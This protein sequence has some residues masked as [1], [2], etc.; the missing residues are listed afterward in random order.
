VSLFARTLGVLLRPQAAAEVSVL[1]IDE[2]MMMLQARFSIVVIIFVLSASPAF[3]KNTPKISPEELAQ[4]TERGR[5]LYAYDQAAWHATDAV[6]TTQPTKGEDGRYIARKTEAGW[7]AAFG[8]LSEA[9]D[10]FLIAHLASQGKTPQEFSV[11][12]FTTPKADTGF[13]FAAAKAVDLELKDFQGENVQ[14]NV[15]VLP[16]SEGQVY[17]YVL[18]A[19]TKNSVYPLGGDERYTVSSDGN[20]LIAKHRMHHSILNF[21][22]NDP[23]TAKI[24]A[25][26]HVHVLS[27]VPED[28]DVFY[29]LTRRPPI[30]EFIG[31]D[32][33]LRFQIMEDGSIQLK[34]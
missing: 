28:S 15:A 14:Y 18:P 4:I 31:V 24:V 22:T 33:K 5:A 21:D 25:G 16:A 9:R 17:V 29:V 3:S 23:Q 13:Y 11:E 26:Y 8:H 19:Q 7:I 12:H 6:V 27:D 2:R 30:P 32:G 1:V 20:T 34:K 10:A